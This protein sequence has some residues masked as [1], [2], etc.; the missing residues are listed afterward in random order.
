MP[1]TASNNPFHQRL[2]SSDG[3]QLQHAA[4]FGERAF[5]VSGT[6]HW[7][8][9]LET[10]CATAD[11]RMFKKNLKIYYSNICFGKF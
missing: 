10:V 3:M 1:P 11:T 5:C 7:N 4:K 6:L 2:H 9:L 8:S